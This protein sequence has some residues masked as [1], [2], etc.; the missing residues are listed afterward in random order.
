MSKNINV[1]FRSLFFVPVCFV[2]FMMFRNYALTQFAQSAQ[3]CQPTIHPKSVEEEKA[4]AKE[5]VGCLQKNNRVLV[6]WYLKPERLTNIFEPHTPCQWVGRWQAKRD[7]ISFAI[8][9]KA[10]STYRIDDESMAALE[11]LREG[12]YSE[13]YTGIWSSPNKKTI[14]WFASGHIWPIDE[15]KVDWLN[16]DQLVI[17]EKS[18]EQT[19]YQRQS[20]HIANCPYY[21]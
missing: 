14:M 7:K 8:E 9:L 3:F 2:A 13:G 12:E 6:L 5:F 20:A 4:L 10:N 1:F 16:A 11:Q 15:N 18:G 19:H 21:P 17:H